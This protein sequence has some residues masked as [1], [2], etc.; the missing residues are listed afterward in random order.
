[1]LHEILW[2]DLSRV[3]SLLKVIDAEMTE[4]N[5]IHNYEIKF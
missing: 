1:M 4:Q 5:A 3:Q 2:I